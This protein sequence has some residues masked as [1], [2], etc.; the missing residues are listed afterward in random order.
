[1]LFYLRN[2]AHQSRLG[3]HIGDCNEVRYQYIAVYLHIEIRLLHN[4]LLRV[5]VD[6]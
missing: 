6:A 1:M 5:Q 2:F 3:S 4:E